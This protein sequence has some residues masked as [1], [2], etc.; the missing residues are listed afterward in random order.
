MTHYNPTDNVE[1]GFTF[2]MRGKKYSVRYPRME[3]LERV[4]DLNIKLEEAD[5]AKDHLLVRQLS[6]EIE[7]AMYA[8]ITPDSHD[9]PIREALK[10][11]NIR[12]ARNFNTMLRTELSLQ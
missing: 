3:E 9:M 8:F 2:D 5:E 10:A 4:R 11:E 12:V 1:D 7:D 6:T